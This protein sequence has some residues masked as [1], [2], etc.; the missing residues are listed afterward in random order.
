MHMGCIVC[1]YIYILYYIIFLDTSNLK[2]RSVYPTC[3]TK[4]WVVKYAIVCLIMIALI[5]IILQ[6]GYHFSIEGSYRH[7][8]GADK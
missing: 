5:I 2:K 4:G 1:V 7:W 3:G 8:S 6:L